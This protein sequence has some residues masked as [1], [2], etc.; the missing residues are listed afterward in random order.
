MS[1]RTVRAAIAEDEPQARRTLRAYL[2]AVDWIEL[3]G[4][5]SDGASAVRLVDETE[6]DLLFLDVRLPELTGLQVVDNPGR[7]AVGVV[8]L[9]DAWGAQR[10]LPARPTS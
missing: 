4:E 6:P 2:E 8:L 9:A 1:A 10:W 5:A 3:A 7:C